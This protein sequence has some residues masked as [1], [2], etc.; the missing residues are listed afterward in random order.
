MVNDLE[1]AIQQGGD[2]TPLFKEPQMDIRSAS[3]TSC[4]ENQASILIIC[5]FYFK[6]Y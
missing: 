4:T 2:A 6:K 5:L 1:R 3:E